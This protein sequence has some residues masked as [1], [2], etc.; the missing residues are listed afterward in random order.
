MVDTVRTLA[1]LQ[2]LLADNATG[3]ISPQDLRDMLVSVYPIVGANQMIETKLLGADTTTVSFTNIDQNFLDLMVVLH[4]K[5]TTAGDIQQLRMRVGDASIDTGSNYD[6][7]AATITDDATNAAS[8]EQGAT[9]WMCART[10]VA[11]GNTDTAAFSSL[12]VMVPNYTS[13]AAR[14]A[15]SQSGGGASTSDTTVNANR[16]G[17]S[18]GMWRDTA[19]IQFIDFFGIADDLAQNSRITLYGMGHVGN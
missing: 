14:K 9:S 13:T 10:I 16:V 7:I 11:A 4:V 3:E 15:F 18:H 12:V 17:F 19:K 6:S 8:E 2:T 1:A 5:S